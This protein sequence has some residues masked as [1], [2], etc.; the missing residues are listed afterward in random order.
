MSRCAIGQG[1]YVR[2][3]RNRNSRKRNRNERVPVRHP[4]GDRQKLPGQSDRG[5]QQSKVASGD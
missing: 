5:G 4:G 3:R 1:Q 2:A